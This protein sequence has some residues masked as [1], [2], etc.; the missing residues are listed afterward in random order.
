ME[1]LRREGHR[2]DDWHLAAMEENNSFTPDE[3]THGGR[4]REQAVDDA[5][6]EWIRYYRD[7]PPRVRRTQHEPKQREVSRLASLRRQALTALY[8]AEAEKDPAVQAFRRTHLDGQLLPSEPGQVDAACRDWIT[9][10]GPEFFGR[11]MSVRRVA[12]EPDSDK[13]HEMPEPLR[14]LYALTEKLGKR[15]DWVKGAATMFVLSGLVP[16]VTTLRAG[17]RVTYD[18]VS[19]SR[20]TMVIDPAT[21]PE[22]VRDLYQYVRKSDSFY[23][24]DANLR[25]LL[26]KS[27]LLAAFSASCTDQERPVEQVRRWN[28]EHPEH[29]YDADHSRAVGN[30]RRDLRQA[31][32]RLL[33]P[34]LGAFGRHARKDG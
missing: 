28:S 5:V 16:E 1:R 19:A 13:H 6:T 8:A 29:A 20:I 17:G 34:K 11:L 10:R 24:A 32:D 22:D 25:P 9:A 30:F 27:L 4:A 15:Y 18:W 26:E 23:G 7:A 2:P 33:N 31:R 14:D 21:S 12:D 3:E